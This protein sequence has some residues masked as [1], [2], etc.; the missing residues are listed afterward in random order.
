MLLI[1]FVSIDEILILIPVGV[2]RQ[3]TCSKV[4]APLRNS[5]V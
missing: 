2:L 3:G 1:N 4:S 5:R